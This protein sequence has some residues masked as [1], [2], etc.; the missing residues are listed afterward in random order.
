MTRIPEITNM[1]VN[2]N[3]GVSTV[4]LLILYSLPRFLEFTLPMS[5]MVA[6]LLTFM[7]MAGSNEII[8]L[9]GGGMSIYR[10]LPPVVF[11]CVLVSLVTVWVTVWA[12]PRGRYAFSVKG[13]EM[14]RSSFNLALKA[15]QFNT[16]LD[17]VMIYV[18]A[19]DVKT[20]TLQDLYIEDAR[21]PHAVAITVAARGKLLSGSDVEGVTLRLARGSINQVVLDRETAQQ[22]QFD[23]YDIHFD[24]PRTARTEGR[25]IDRDLDEL[26]M[27]A[28][29]ARMN[30]P[31]VS[32]KQRRAAR[33]EFHE[34]LAIPVACLVL[35]LLAMAVGLQSLSARQGSGFGMAFF[36][37]LAYYLLLAFG[38]SA[39]ETG[40]CPPAVAIWLPNAV[41]GLAAFY[42]LFRVAR[43]NPVRFPATA[44]VWLW[45]NRVFSRKERGHVHH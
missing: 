24:L 33:L 45:I 34:K 14:A 9:K 18:N 21:D 2:Y 22:I 29:M 5:V 3:T 41:L 36:F 17:G 35:G 28:L 11:F 37:F 38:W 25:T 6:V 44:V 20:G 23:T 15:R 42:M 7:R 31:D 43:E 10:L 19:I 13:A 30:A 12:V 32:P 16:P 1:V 8:A 40:A 26:D 39:G 27:G 4:F